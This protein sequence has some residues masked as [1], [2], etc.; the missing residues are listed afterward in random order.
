MEE[1]FLSAK[2]FAADLTSLIEVEVW[3]IQ[4]TWMTVDIRREC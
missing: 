1:I 4:I 3:K 2:Q